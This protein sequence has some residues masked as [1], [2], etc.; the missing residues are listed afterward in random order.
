MYAVIKTGGKQYR[1][2]EGDVVRVEKLAGEQGDTI[3]FDEV[4][5]IGEGADVKVGSPY[6]SGTQ[7]SATVLGHGRGDKIKIVKFKR[8]KNYLRRKGH[9]QAY[10]ELE[11]TAIGGAGKAAAKP[12]A[13]TAK[14][15]AAPESAPKAKPKASAKTG[16]KPTTKKKA[17]AKP[18]T[19]KKTTKK[20]AKAKAT[21]KKKKK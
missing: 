9:R 5:M 12:K 17:K 6:V 16:D 19:K 3:R 15:E 13:E 8:R 4:L 1:V 21:S 7:V 11:I 2:R 14:P 10:T 18:T 20:K